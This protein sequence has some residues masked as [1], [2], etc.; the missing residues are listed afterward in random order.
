MVLEMERG[1]LS[2]LVT[3]RVFD[4]LEAIIENAEGRR[5]DVG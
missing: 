4:V 1:P 5:V 2:F 3:I